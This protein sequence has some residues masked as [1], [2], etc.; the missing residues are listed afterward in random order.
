[1]VVVTVVAGGLGFTWGANPCS[2]TGCCMVWFGRG[3]VS[4]AW[5]A[6]GS[7]LSRRHHGLLA[8]RSNPSHTPIFHTIVAV[9]Y[10]PVV[11][12]VTPS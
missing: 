7:I 12:A 5:R 1:M 8:C 3:S 4:S 10:L 6:A 11:N 2:I 9:R